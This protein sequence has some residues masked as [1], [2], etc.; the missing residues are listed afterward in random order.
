MVSG[1]SAYAQDTLDTAAAAG[2]AG[3]DAAADAPAAASPTFESNPT[4]RA[5]LELPRKEPGDYFQ[6]IGWLID[7]GR[8]E[9]ARPIL[10]ELAN[11]QMTDAQRAEL[12]TEFGSQRM[13][14][15]ARSAELAPAGAAFADACMSAAAAIANDPRR[16]SRLVTQLTDPSREVR[17]IARNDLAAVG[18][19]GVV[20][21]LEALA[22]EPDLHRR[23]ALSTAAAQ[24]RPLVDGPLLAMLS[25]NDPTLRAEVHGLLRQLRIVQAIPLL[26]TASVTSAERALTEALSRYAAGTPPFA[27][28]ESNHVELWHWDDAARRLRSARYPADEARV[29][30]SSRLARLLVQ[31]R[32]ENR[33]YQRQA[34]VLGLEAAGLINTTRGM[35]DAADTGFL[36]DILAD[37]LAV[38]YPHAAMA[39]ADELG[40]WRDASV[41]YTGDGQPSPLAAALAHSNRDVQFA[42]L[43]AIMAIDPTSPYPGSSR[44]PE[45]LEWFANAAGERRAV[46]AMPTDLDATDLAGMLAAHGLEAD[47][48]NRGRDAIDLAHAAADIDMIF[49]DMDILLPDVRQVLYELRTAPATAQIPIAILAADGRLPAA[50]RLASEHERAIAT[51]RPHSPEVLARVVDQ[52]NNLA[53]RSAVSANERAD[54][55]AQAMTWLSQL[56]SRD[57]TFYD[58]V[59]TAPAIELALYRP[60]TATTAIAALAKLGTPEG[61]RTLVNLASQSTLPGSVRRDATQAFRTSV[62]AR[63]VLLTTDEILAQYDRYNA[64][65]A[66]DAETQE[67]LGSVLDAI[68]SRRDARSPTPPPGL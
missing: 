65:A 26:P 66:A 41:L 20:A 29:I 24:M 49:V 44:L 28:D 35:L 23:A 50:S 39:V 63:G 59:R 6:A 45:A 37:A 53:G 33:A 55:A 25:T 30:W 40:R 60:A 38:N 7:L 58:L 57:R 11:L 22:R 43:R 61:Q 19:A 62:Q 48:A 18:Q 9:L 42:A 32:P 12:V 16:I 31:L 1:A 64:S 21:M 56:L 3:A 15:L 36:N 13:L 8:P 68:E 34:W 17:A 5:A 4:V 51:P 54:Q 67:I 2:D 27:A 14:Q 52:L 10:D 46:V 47:A